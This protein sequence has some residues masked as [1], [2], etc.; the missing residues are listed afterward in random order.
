MHVDIYMTEQCTCEM[1]W[2]AEQL[3]Y[4]D[5]SYA[6]KEDALR[7]HDSSWHD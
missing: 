6:S 7:P 4:L 1:G 2:C 3:S 5:D